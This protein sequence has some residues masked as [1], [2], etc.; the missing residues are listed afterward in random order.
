MDYPT[1]RLQEKFIRARGQGSW[2]EDPWGS[3][4]DHARYLRERNRFVRTTRW[5]ST[6]QTCAATTVTLC[7]LL[8]VAQLSWTASEGALPPPVEDAP[9]APRASLERHE[10]SPIP[11][12]IER[13][14]SGQATGMTPATSEPEVLATG[15][16]GATIRVGAF[17]D[18]TN[19]ERLASTLRQKHD[20]VDVGLTEEG[21]RPV[22]RQRAGAGDSRHRFCDA[23]GPGRGSIERFAVPALR[24]RSSPLP[25][26]NRVSR[27]RPDRRRPSVSP[28]PGR[29]VPV[30]PRG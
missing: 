17:R 13:T 11:A 20:R 8:G 4:H 18:R 7:L 10:P 25:V 6:G 23:S 24:M 15:I 28:A 16:S 22:D 29:R 9:A 5:A 27:R 21:C 19:A 2:E 12:A 3:R 30:P 1:P 26:P 14:A